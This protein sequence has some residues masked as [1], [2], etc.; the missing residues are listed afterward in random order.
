MQKKGQVHQ[1][2]E[3]HSSGMHKEGAVLRQG[4]GGHEISAAVKDQ[5]V[6]KVKKTV[7]VKEKVKNKVEDQVEKKAQVDVKYLFRIIVIVVVARS[8]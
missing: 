5:V 7:E 2:A 4:A 3:C 8:V 6:E 1:G